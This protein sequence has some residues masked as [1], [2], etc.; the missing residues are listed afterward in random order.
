M[1]LFLKAI[2][3]IMVSCLVSCK[4]DNQKLIINNP[5]FP[6]KEST[7]VSYSGEFYF[8]DFIKEDGTVQIDLVEKLEDGYVYKM[9]INT[10]AKL[11]GEEDVFFYVTNNEIRIFRSSK[12][13]SFEN[14][15]YADFVAEG[16]EN[17]SKYTQLIC[18]ADDIDL[19]D[20]KMEMYI[21]NDGDICTFVTVNHGVETGFYQ[22]ILFKKDVGLVKYRRGFG[23]Q[24]DHM[25][26]VIKE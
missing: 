23:A 5:Y 4:A 6:Y 20:D 19:S 25:D 1:R 13:P 16:K 3:L 17:L 11:S 2:T 10:T 24:R 14:T 26:I 18:T 9:H 12:E 22:R 7:T 21:E 8:D 15:C